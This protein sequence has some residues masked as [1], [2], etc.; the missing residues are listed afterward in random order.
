ML[1]RFVVISA[2]ALSLVSGAAARSKDSALLQSFAPQSATTW[3]AVVQSNLTSRSWVVRTTDTGTHWRDVTAPTKIV[4]SSAFAG[5][6]AAWI[7]GAAAGTAQPVY[8]TLD[9]GGTWRRVGSVPTECRLDFVDLRH[10]WC[11]SINGAAGS[12][13]VQLAR[14]V[15]GGVSWKQVSRTGL[16]D[17]DS[18]PGALPFGCDKTI[19]F[20]SPTAGWAAQFCNGGEPRLYASTDGGAHWTALAA[21]PLPK[22]VLPSAGIGL[23]P[24]ARSGSRLVVSVNVGGLPHGAT[25]IATSADGG[26]SWR[27]Q[28]IPGP[29]RYWTVDLI[30]VRHWIAGDG[31]AVA[32]TADG[33]RHWRVSTPASRMTDGV[34]GQLDLRFLSPQLE[35][36]R[37]HV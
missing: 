31:T 23:S 25:L 37:A 7:E 12:E 26:R 36:G 33:G 1:T 4:V 29:L 6:R 34:G 15:D 35:I 16:S 14:T 27:T 22:E 18:T 30:D 3:W 32:A 8:R 19:A 9:G 13:T 5:R 28:R 24:P 17:K 2:V 20:T 21:V 11:A 10:G